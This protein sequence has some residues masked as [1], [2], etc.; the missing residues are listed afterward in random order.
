M[1]QNK[2]ELNFTK[3]P[4]GLIPIIV[5]D[6]K[7]GRVMMLAYANKEALDLTIKSRY[8]TFWSRSKNEIWEKGST[9]GD[10]LLVKRILTDCDYDSLIY[11]VEVTTNNGACHKKEFWSCF[12]NEIDLFTQKTTRPTKSL[13]KWSKVLFEEE[14]MIEN[15][16]KADPQKS[17]TAESINQSMPRVAQKFGEEAV[18]VVC[19]LSAEESKDC[20]IGEVA[21]LMYRLQIALVKAKIK[22]KDVENKIINRRK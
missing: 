8:A 10:Y 16:Q 22:W 7:T 15:K 12:E 3:H 9:S 20:L 17:V 6:E 5:Q 11:E 14:L 2:I 1:S 19:A 18:E 21:D 4:D 13:S